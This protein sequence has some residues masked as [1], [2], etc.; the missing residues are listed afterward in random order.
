MSPFWKAPYK[1]RRA[2]KMLSF[3]V[4]QNN[5]LLEVGGEACFLL[6]RN[7]RANSPFQT[8]SRRV[9]TVTETAS[10]HSY[11][12]DPDTGVLRYCLWSAS[13]DSVSTYPDI[14]TLTATVQASGG[15]TV[16]EPAVDKYSFITDRDEYTFDIFQDEIDSDG[17]TITDAVY[18]VFSTPPFTADN[19]VYFSFGNINP[20]VNFAA[21]QPVR[22]NEAE[23]QRSLFGFEQW[24]NPF[25]RIRKK[26][27]PNSFLLAFPGVKS[28]FEITESGL[29]R[30][31]RADF[32]TVPPPY[33]PEIVEHDVVVRPSTTQRFQ[34]VNY[35]PIYIEHTLVSQHFDMVEL[36]PRSSI[37]N[38]EYDAGC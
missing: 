19:T 31:T 20:L 32:W 9:S 5:T 37:Y 33:S 15:T 2:N 23:F 1:T 30:E 21:M 22:D 35:T 6:K 18:V 36:D 12:I 17:D 3:A 27:A 16:W 24:M 13:T 11:S 8:A 4:K 28:D 29:L 10:S 26:H 34:I 38:I 14:G 7:T 25:P